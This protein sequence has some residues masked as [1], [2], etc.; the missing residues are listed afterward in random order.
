MSGVSVA[1]RK[2]LFTCIL[3]SAVNRVVQVGYNSFAGGCQGGEILVFQ[4][5]SLSQ[6]IKILSP[7][8]SPI[9]DLLIHPHKTDSNI[10]SFWASKGDGTCVLINPSIQPCSK[11][12]QLTGPDCDPV[13]QLR[14]DLDFIYSACRDGLIRKYS[15]KVINSLAGLP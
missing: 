11:V 7:T 3:P 10:S 12:I 2:E 14:N 5:N 13:Y 4:L 1:A 6:P 9:L 8:S 15:L